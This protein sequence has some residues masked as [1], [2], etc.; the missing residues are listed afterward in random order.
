MP[1]P[2]AGGDFTRR[3]KKRK[4]IRGRHH[5]SIKTLLIN[6]KYN[7]NGDAAVT[8]KLQVFF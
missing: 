1:F 5:P 3:V 2:S 7:Q 4:T 8:P 6:R